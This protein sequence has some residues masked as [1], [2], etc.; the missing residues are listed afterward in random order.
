[1]GLIWS[2]ERGKIHNS[3][4]LNEEK[5]ELTQDDSDSDCEEIFFEAVD[6]VPSNGDLVLQDLDTKNSCVKE[7][8]EITCNATYEE[9]STVCEPEQKIPESAV[10][11]ITSNINN[12]NAGTSRVSFIATEE[13]KEKD[14]KSEKWLTNSSWKVPPL[15]REEDQVME[16]STFSLPLIS[17]EKV[18]RG[19][20]VKSI[21]DPQMFES[22]NFSHQA[23]PEIPRSCS[24]QVD[25]D[26]FKPKKRK[27]PP[28]KYL[29]DKEHDFQ[30]D[31]DDTKH[32]T[33]A[34]NKQDLYKGSSLTSMETVTQEMMAGRKVLDLRRWYCM[35]R[36]QYKHSCG[37]SSLV[38][39]WNFLFSSLGAGS[40]QPLT[41]EEALS[42]LGFKPPFAEIRFGPF[43]GNATLMRWF[44]QLCEY[45]GVHGEA[46]FLY[47]PKGK[48]RTIGL[49]GE[50]ALRQLKK[51]LH[52]PQMAFIYHCY[53]HYFCPIGY[54]DSPVKAVDAYRVQLYEDEVETW[55]LIGDPSCKYPS[56]HCKRWTDIETDL[57]NEAPLYLNIRQLHKGIQQKNVKKTGGNLHC[58]MAFQKS[59]WQHY[60]K[61]TPP[62][63]SKRMPQVEED[64]IDDRN[65]SDSSDS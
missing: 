1:M 57:N 21:S 31:N 43:T 46:Y 63:S 26:C 12:F 44:R 30:D 38:S 32:R 52:N 24:W 65:S 49:S 36:P 62:T 3:S 15:L 35:S 64:E 14:F 20:H 8:Y 60:N 55:I 45:F 56:I 18:F 51:G 25:V 11:E 59:T 41:Q 16:C 50:E 17:E 19:K 7:S 47:K 39:C 4:Q 48:S 23:K 29:R 53:N 33:A 27:K 6:N 42:I 10:H 5:G 40:K 34:S 13:C 58:I 9:S 37:I 28:K 22:V 61:I 54:D 2:T